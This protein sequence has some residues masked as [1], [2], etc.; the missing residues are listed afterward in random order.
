VEFLQLFCNYLRFKGG[1][2][3]LDC[4]RRKRERRTTVPSVLI[5][6]FLFLSRYAGKENGH[7]T[8]KPAAAGHNG[9]FDT[10]KQVK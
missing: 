8:L 6:F 5:S 9:I 3:K 10:N 4:K 7:F 1:F 2:P